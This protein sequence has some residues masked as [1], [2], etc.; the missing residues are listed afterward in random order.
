MDQPLKKGEDYTGVTVVY[1]CHDGRGNYLLNKRS[2]RT[3]DE[4]GT[5]DAGGGSLEFNDTVEG[6]LRK[7]IKEEYCTDVIAYEFLGFRDVHRV[8]EGRP[9]HWLAL[10]FKVLVNREMV[11]NGEPHKFD[12][13]GWFKLEEFPKPLH[14]QFPFFL[15]K[16]KEKIVMGSYLKSLPRKRM[17]SGVILRNPKGEILVLKTTYKDHWEIPGGVV[18]EDES[19]KQTAE[20]ETKEETG[21]SISITACLVMHYRSAQ[22]NQNENIMFVFDGGVIEDVAQLKL[23]GKE[24]SEARFVSFH[25]AIPLVGERLASRL[26][27]CERALKEKKTI[28]LESIDNIEPTFIS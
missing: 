27:A 16:Y 23:D 26:P 9:T 25:D 7:E 19:P 5:W 18:E 11:K 6:T 15:E 4:H 13:I 3:R 2:N 12:E 8:H 24:I 22:G 21:L 20:R 14:S 17:G 28:Y 1:L 10:D